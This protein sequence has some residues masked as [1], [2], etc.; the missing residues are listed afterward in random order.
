[1]YT[2]KITPVSLHGPSFEPQGMIF[3]AS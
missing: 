3:V 2:G 1:M